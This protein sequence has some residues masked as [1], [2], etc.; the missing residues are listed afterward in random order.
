MKEEMAKNYSITKIGLIS[1]V[2]FITLMLFYKTV[3]TLCNSIS[4]SGELNICSLLLIVA[5]DQMAIRTSTG[6]TVY[7][8]FSFLEFQQ[9]LKF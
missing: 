8:I 4:N 9:W 7:G 2:T 5:I 6:L 3:L 1:I